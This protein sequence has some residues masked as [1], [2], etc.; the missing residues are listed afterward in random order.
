MLSHVMR[1]REDLSQSGHS[2]AV[3][4]WFP[5]GE[6]GGEQLQCLTCPDCSSREV[7]MSCVKVTF[8][9]TAQGHLGFL[10]G[11]NCF[12]TVIHPFKTMHKAVWIHI[13][14]RIRRRLSLKLVHTS[15]MYI[16]INNCGWIKNF[17]SVVLLLQLHLRKFSFK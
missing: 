10:A 17:I 7:L 2:S 12:Q 16:T 8:S 5:A 3:R 14:T 6:A 13:Y 9:D 11:M 1:V 15:P 4:S